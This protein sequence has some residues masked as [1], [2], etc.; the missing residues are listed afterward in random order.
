M[1]ARKNIS[2]SAVSNAVEKGL[3]QLSLSPYA[4]A[5]LASIDLKK[6]E[7]GILRYAAAHD[8]PFR[9]FGKEA[10]L[11]VPGSFTE[12]AFVQS[13]TG[14]P[15]VCERAA[16]KVAGEEA[17]LLLRKQIYDGVTIAVACTAAYCVCPEDEY[18]EIP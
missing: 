8:L 3:T 2:E 17:R 4:V 18:A 16:M 7:T 1:G 6:D 13:V 5:G 14:V 9:T 10:L 12:S 15:N 11:A